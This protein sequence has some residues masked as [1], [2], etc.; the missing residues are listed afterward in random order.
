MDDPLAAAAALAI[1]LTK[2]RREEALGMARLLT[3]RFSMSTHL[4]NR[5]HCYSLP[6]DLPIA[7]LKHILQRELHNPGILSGSDFTKVQVVQ[8][9]VRIVRAESV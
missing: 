3:S 6:N 7:N 2:V 9:C 1:V 5:D 4:W 8:R